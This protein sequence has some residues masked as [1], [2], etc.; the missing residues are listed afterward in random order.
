MVPDIDAALKFYRDL[1]GFRITDF[2]GP[3]VSLYFM[4]VNTRHH[5]LAIAQGSRSR[6]HYMHATS[7]SYSRPTTYS[8][9]TPPL[10]RLALLLR[11]DEVDNLRFRLH[12]P[13]DLADLFLR[14]LGLGEPDAV[15]RASHVQR[16]INQLGLVGAK[17]EP[18][19]CQAWKLKSSLLVTGWMANRFRSMCGLFQ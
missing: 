2:M 12:L 9:P 15:D 17:K 10:T 4:H 18:R 8:P 19:I 1:L 13:N 3:P 11:G 7:L 5:S 16:S 6:M 14:Q